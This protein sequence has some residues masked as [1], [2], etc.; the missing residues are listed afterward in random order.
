VNQYQVHVPKLSKVNKI[1]IILSG[2][3]FLLESIL[4]KLFG[5]SLLLYLALSGDSFFSGHFYQIL[6]YPFVGGGFFE[7]LFNGLLIWFV[8]SELEDIWGKRKYL[9]FLIVATLGA[10]LIFLLISNLISGVKFPFFGLMGLSNFLLMAYAIIFPNRLFTFMFIFP[11]KAKYFCLFIIGIQLFSGIFSPM[12]ALSLGH[13]GAMATGYIHM[14][15]GS[16]PSIKRKAAFI[17]SY[18]GVGTKQ[19]QRDFKKSHL[20]LLKSSDES[21][22]EVQGNRATKKDGGDNDPPPK[23][24]GKPPKYWQ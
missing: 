22:N 20:K 15:L 17:I 2:S 16:T 23:G 10:G 18:F 9:S 13:L 21:S 4:H 5:K 12:G 6:S 19:K 8:G 14:V 24:G 3:L 7:V 1:I 11:M